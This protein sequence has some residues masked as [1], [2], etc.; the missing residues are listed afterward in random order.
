M[1][2]F[3]S[4][5]DNA[6]TEKSLFELKFVFQITALRHTTQT[7]S[8]PA[9]RCQMKDPEAELLFFNQKQII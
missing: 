5:L 7:T 3:L 2:T 8:T 4:W 9:S 6:L 1:F